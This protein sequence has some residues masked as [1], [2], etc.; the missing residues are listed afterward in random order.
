MA[1]KLDWVCVSPKANARLK[2]TKGHELKLVY[3]Q[4]ENSPDQ[5]EELEFGHFYLQPCDDV[6]GS[7]RAA[8]EYC[9]KHPLWKLSLQTHKMIGI[10]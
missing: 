7:R 4:V 10:E 8:V 2:L 9:M 5:F 1:A 6:D 3:P